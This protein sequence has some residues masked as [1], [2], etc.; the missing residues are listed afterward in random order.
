[1]ALYRVPEHLGILV[2]SGAHALI[3]VR[4]EGLVEG[5][6]DITEPATGDV[7]AV[8][9]DISFSPAQRRLWMTT[10]KVAERDADDLEPGREVALVHPIYDP[11]D[12]RFAETLKSPLGVLWPFLWRAVFIFVGVRGI[13]RNWPAAAPPGSGQG[14]HASGRTSVQGAGRTGFGR[15]G[16]GR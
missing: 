9:L 3:G 11:Q 6:R 4:A 5:R 7:R 1:V 12:V 13:Q 15:R 14:R 2:D 16:A 8:L 10:L